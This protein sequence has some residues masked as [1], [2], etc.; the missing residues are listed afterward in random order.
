[1]TFRVEMKLRWWF[2]YFYWPCLEATLF[3]ARQ[4]NEDAEPDWE[5]LEY[6]ITKAIVLTPV[7][8]TTKTNCKL[9]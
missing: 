7:T 5:R 8:Q 6:W 4:L 2:L 9:S 1:M 3:I